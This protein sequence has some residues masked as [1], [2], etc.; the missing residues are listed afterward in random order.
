MRWS[1][2]RTHL[3]LLFVGDDLRFHDF[4]EGRLQG[5]WL[6]RPIAIDGLRNGH[7]SAAVTTGGHLGLGV[8]SIFALADMFPG[9]NVC[10]AIDRDQRC[11][12]R[13]RLAVQSAV[14]LAL[15][16]PA[17]QLGTVPGLVVSH[18]LADEAV[19]HPDLDGRT[20]GLLQTLSA[21]AAPAKVF[22]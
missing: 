11:S 16:R 2:V 6:Q 7:A 14:A 19:G 15:A 4:S 20:D 12:R 21:A 18:H 1:Q 22:R 10:L 8:V 5:D 3:A 9:P 13:L 17:D